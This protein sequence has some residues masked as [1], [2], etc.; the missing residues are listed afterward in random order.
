MFFTAPDT[1]QTTHQTPTPIY[2]FID[3]TLDLVHPLLLLIQLLILSHPS[4]GQYF[5]IELL[6]GEFY[7]SDVAEG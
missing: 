5:D 7:G 1:P 4:S 3:P 2:P 6:K